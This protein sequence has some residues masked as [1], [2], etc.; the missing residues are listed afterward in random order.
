[1]FAFAAS[2]CFG[3]IAPPSELGWLLDMLPFDGGQFYSPAEGATPISGQLYKYNPSIEQP[4]AKAV[5][6]IAIPVPVD[7][8]DGRGRRLPPVCVCHQ[9][10]HDVR[11][12][13]KH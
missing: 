9:T 5:S 6:Q 13:G 10:A 3:G 11:L 2:G 7:L 4:S 1:M 8:I 12:R